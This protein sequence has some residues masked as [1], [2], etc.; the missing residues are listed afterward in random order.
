M[1]KRTK[2]IALLMMVVGVVLAVAGFRYLP[3][4]SSATGGKTI[5]MPAQQKQFCQLLINAARE[6]QRLNDSIRYSNNDLR[7]DAVNAQIA[8]IEPKLWHDLYALIGP[9][10]AFTNWRGGLRVVR[11]SEPQ[12]KGTLFVSMGYCNSR[13]LVTAELMTGNPSLYH[14]QAQIANTFIPA[15]SPLAQQLAS[16]DTNREVIASGKFVWEPQSQ[17]EM[18][19]KSQWMHHYFVSP[20]TQSNPSYGDANL[21]VSFTAITQAP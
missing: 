16:I 13:E 7:N 15:N 14:G 17:M 4:G 9:S 3:N 10:G 12:L 2:R 6:S 21:L 20:R 1:T 18:E 5:N 19:E 8:K 11:N